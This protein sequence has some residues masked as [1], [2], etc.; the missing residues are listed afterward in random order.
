MM[1][2][3]TVGPRYLNDCDLSPGITYP[4][5]CVYL[6]VMIVC[7]LGNVPIILAIFR[8][9]QYHRPTYYYLASIAVSDILM[10]LSFPLNLM[11][12]LDK[13]WLDNDVFCAMMAYSPYCFLYPS[14]LSILSTALCRYIQVVHSNKL[15]LFRKRWFLF[16]MMGFTWMAGP[17]VVICRIITTS[18]ASSYSLFVNKDGIC[19]LAETDV[20]VKIGRYMIEYPSPIV[21]VY[22]YVHIYCKY[23]KNKIKIGNVTNKNLPTISSAVSGGPDQ[24]SKNRSEIRNKSG[25]MSANERMLTHGTLFICIV[26]FVCWTIPGILN[27]I[28]PHRCEI[29]QISVL[30]VRTSPL[31]NVIIILGLNSRLRQSI[32]LLLSACCKGKPRIH[33]DI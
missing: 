26:Y 32:F 14:N 29:T 1:N 21:M 17:T 18:I 16:G 28:R 3:S 33:P 13:R 20:C 19:R 6:L 9:R 11:S 24:Q 4:I 31:F 22:Y 30:I 25:N 10:C 5:I 8:F 27:N 12:L 15:Q 23:R 2:N 7:F